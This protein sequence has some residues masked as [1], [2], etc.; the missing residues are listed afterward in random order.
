MSRKQLSF[1]QKQIIDTLSSSLSPEDGRG[2]S[3][4]ELI[5][6]LR[7]RLHMS[8][9]Q[10]AKRAG[11]PQSFI[12]K[13]ESGKQEPNLK[14]L[15]KL[16]WALTCELVIVP[17]VHRSFDE[18]LKKQARKYVEKHFQ[19]VEGTMSLE[20]QLPDPKFSKAFLEE[21]VQKLLYSGSSEI[22]EIE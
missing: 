20:K 6:L 19:Y 21:E 4:G 3:E 9:K 13:I 12:S 18:I 17:V 10:L 2:I 5:A 7:K 1:T 22:W 14:T 16:F 8:Q 15:R 11:L